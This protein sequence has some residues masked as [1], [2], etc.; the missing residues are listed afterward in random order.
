MGKGRITPDNLLQVLLV[1]WL[2][3]PTLFGFASM[4]FGGQASLARGL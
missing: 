3:S 2:G 1:P 4:A